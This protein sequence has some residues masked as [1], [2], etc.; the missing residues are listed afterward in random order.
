MATMADSLVNS[1]MRP[2]KLRKRADLHT[3]RNTYDGRTYWVVKDPVGLNYFRFHEEEFAILQMLDG[4][5]SL[6]TI[7]E[8]FQ[9]KFAPQRITLQDL[10]QFIGML[11]RSGLV[12]SQSVGQGRQLR[13]RGDQKKKK[14]LLGKVANIFAL[15]FRGI[16]PE[17]ILNRLLP[18]FGWLFTPGALIGALCFGLTALMLVLVQWSKFQA[19]LPT[20]EQFFAADN[21]IFLGVTMALV[22][23]LHEFGHGL[24]CKKFGG[25]CHEM[26]VMLLVFTPCLYCNVSDSWMLR[27]KWERVFIG[28]AGMYVELLLASIATFLWWFSTPGMFNFLCL[29]VMFICSVSTVVFNGNP[30]LRFDGYYILMD[31]LEIPNLRQKSTEVLK[32]WFQSTCLGLELQDNPFLPRRNLFWFGMF[33]VAASIYRWV[34]VFGII[35]FLNQ[36]LK[37][38]GLEVIGQMFAIAGLTGMVV[39][40]MIASYK[41]LKTPGRAAKMKSKNILWSLAVAGAVIAIVGFVP[42]PYSVRCAFEIQPQD[43]IQV[44]AMV[45]GYL[46]GWNKKPGQQV[47]A[48]EPIANLDSIDLAAQE[49]KYRNERDAAK[50][51]LEQ[52]ELQFTDP[53]KNATL[54]TQREMLEAAEELLAQVQAKRAMLTVVS[55]V[56]GTIIEPPSKPLPKAAMAEDQLPG[57]SGNPFSQINADAHFAE[58]DVLCVVGKPDKMEA[59]I[60]IDQSDIDLVHEGDEVE[61]M[62]DSAK[63]HSVSGKI[64]KIAQSE[65]KESPENLASQAGG[66]LNTAQDASGKVR[67][68]STSYQASVPLETQHVPFRSSYR[69]VAKVHLEWRS[70]GWRFYRF[71]VKTFNFDF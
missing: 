42:L 34:V 54:V 31:I 30:L 22:K 17:R 57:W 25:E 27:N 69:G 64:N 18:W 41:F 12:I 20:F 39:Q 36:V 60:I 51:R 61:L 13:R 5:T 56:D 37:P 7:R 10:Q 67:P 49:S 65:M 32:R 14:E 3:S 2:L 52:M 40:P 70:L 55:P 8:T 28:A 66:S 1:A 44:R 58:G 43:A 68:I 6:Q 15:R 62:L 33:T 45:P 48:G 9:A 35:W 63:L 59:V 21:W 47:R 19:K 53:R 38:Y 11:H 71:L 4:E 46:V 23:V 26:G 29:S 16:D 50:V 24:S